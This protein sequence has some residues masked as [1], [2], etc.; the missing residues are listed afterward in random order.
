M[1]NAPLEV[2]FDGDILFPTCDG[3]VRTG[4]AVVDA[5]GNRY[6]MTNNCKGRQVGEI[7][8][9]N[10]DRNTNPVRAKLVT[11]FKI[12]AKGVV[13]WIDG[14]FYVSKEVNHV[15]YCN[16]FVSPSPVPPLVQITQTSGVVT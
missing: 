16:K 13:A 14:I 12:V 5:N 1:I 3:G 11:E 6:L 4:A 15:N 9:W 7:G 8:A 2:K 10:L